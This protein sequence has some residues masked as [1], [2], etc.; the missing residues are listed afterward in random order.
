MKEEDN[1]KQ[2]SLCDSDC[3]GVGLKVY[4]KIHSKVGIV[5]VDYLQCYLCM[6]FHNCIFWLK[7]QIALVIY[8]MTVAIQWQCL[9]FCSWL[10][11]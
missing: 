1:N 6:W 8:S 11:T 9:E 3:L 7:I 4:G 2:L 10:I 5:N